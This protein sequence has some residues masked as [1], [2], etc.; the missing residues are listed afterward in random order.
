MPPPSPLAED[1]SYW[2]AG[3]GA[4]CNHQERVPTLGKSLMPVMAEHGGRNERGAD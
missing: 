2:K 4:E 1:R 3:E